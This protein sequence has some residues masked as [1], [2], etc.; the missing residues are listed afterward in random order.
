MSR[1]D[2]EFKI[3]DMVVKRP[4]AS[5]YYVMGEVVM[6][7]RKSEGSPLQLVIRS[8]AHD[9]LQVGFAS[10]FEMF[11]PDNVIFAHNPN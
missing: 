6:T 5:G 2:E 8:A 7:Y 10:Q 11:D 3:T 1:N 4:D 9:K